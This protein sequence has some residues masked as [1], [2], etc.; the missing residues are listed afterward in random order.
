MSSLSSSTPF[1]GYA[2]EFNGVSISEALGFEIISIAIANEQ[3]TNF[4]KTARKVFKATLPAPGTWETTDSA[5]L[6]WTG[7]NQYMLFQDGMND[8]LD[9]TLSQEFKDMAYFTMQTD[10]WAALDVSGTYIHDVFE[11]FIPLDIAQKPVGFGA[12]TSAHHMSVF[13][14][15]TG[16]ESYLL[17]TPRSSSAAF[18][19]SLEHVIQNIGEEKPG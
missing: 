17:L 12:R 3:S 2:R 7:Q 4:A 8:R 15:K 11:R 10:G 13:I 6:L 14:L 19:E 16:K 9:E 5:R 18:L 1:N